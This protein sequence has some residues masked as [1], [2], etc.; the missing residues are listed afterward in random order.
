MYKRNG[1]CERIPGARLDAKQE[2][3]LTTVRNA[4]SFIKPARTV[5]PHKLI[6]GGCARR[7]AL[8]R[9]QQTPLRAVEEKVAGIGGGHILGSSQIDWIRLVCERAAE[10]VGILLTKQRRRECIDKAHGRVDERVWDKCGSFIADRANESAN[11]TNVMI[12]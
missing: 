10:R 9:C 2:C 12:K 7:G 1:V 5:R 3:N 6:E 11:P 8:G 4:Q